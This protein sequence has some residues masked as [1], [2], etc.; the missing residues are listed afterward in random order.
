MKKTVFLIICTLIIGLL[1]GVF[2]N[3]YQTNRQ[4]TNLFKIKSIRAGQN[5]LVNPLLEYEFGNQFF[6]KELTNFQNK[7]KEKAD[8]LVV[9]GKAQTIA[10]YFRDLNNGPWFGVN[11]DENFFPASLIKVPVLI[12]ALLKSE[13]DPNFL[14]KELTYTD[15]FGDF[16]RFQKFQPQNP[17]E[18]GKSYTIDQLQ[19]SMISDSDNNAFNLLQLELGTDEIISIFTK[20]GLP[21]P[22][23][24]SQE[25]INSPHDY[26]T[27]FRI[28]YN[29]SYLS[30]ENSIK[31]LTTLTNTNFN[32]GIVAGVPENIKVAHKFGSAANGQINQL[33]DCGIIYYPGKP[34][35]LCIMTRGDDFKKLESTIKEISQLVYQEVDNQVSAYK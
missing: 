20:F 33:H 13:T 9:N 11:E 26:S 25:E 21:T 15:E 10:V 4:T 6:G 32:Q 28:L 24:E 17:I 31:A 7:I 1:L 14:S 5:G 18:Q 8:Q 19:K 30:R 23:Y 2:L 34:Y 3:V 12:A 22:S 16:N 29:A 27:F 35:L